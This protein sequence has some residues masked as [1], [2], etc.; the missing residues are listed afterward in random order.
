MIE[1][2]QKATLDNGTVIDL[3][4]KA[5]LVRSGM[6]GSMLGLDPKT[7]REILKEAWGNVGIF[8]HRQL[9]PKHFT[10]RGATEYG[11]QKRVGENMRGEKGFA[12]TYMGRKLREKGHSRPLVF[13]GRMERA[14]KQTR[15]VRA[16]SK[17]VTVV[18]TSLPRYAYQ[19]AHPGDPNKAKELGTISKQDAALM[20]RVLDRE[21]ERLGNQ[22]GGR[23]PSRTRGHR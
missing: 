18:L 21:L 11:Y 23:T 16:T 12:R 15:D 17:G 13:T 7:W 20:A 4:A 5:F 19:I 22:R 10:K 3:N 14:A 9:L 8:W 2:K 1:I 6:K